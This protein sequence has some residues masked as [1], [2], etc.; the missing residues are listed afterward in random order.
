M[1]TFNKTGNVAT[2]GLP[3]ENLIINSVNIHPSHLTSGNEYI[4]VNL[5]QSYMW[6]PNGTRVTFSFD[7][8]MKI[9]KQHATA[10][11]NTYLQIYN[12][13]N[14]GPKT[15]SGVQLGSQMYDDSQVV[16]NTYKKRLY[17]TV[18]LV[19]RD[20]ST[21]TT[22]NNYIEF[23]SYYGSGNVFAVSNIKC[24]LGDVVTPWIP[25]PADADYI[26]YCDWGYVETGNNL[27][28]YNTKILANEFIEY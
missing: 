1:V 16:G 15:F 25:N 12:S 26:D 10:S 24:E 14:R 27:K 5:G 17:A 13:N 22:D 8:E 6:V 7:I 9:M 2:D 21:V 4:A 3:N 19:D 28:V 18:T 23:Y 20:P 11:Y